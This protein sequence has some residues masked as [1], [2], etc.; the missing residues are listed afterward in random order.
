MPEGGMP[1][2]SIPE[3]AKSPPQEISDAC[4]LPGGACA[5]PHSSVG[6]E[7]GPSSQSDEGVPARKPPRRNSLFNALL[8]EGTCFE[9][10]HPSELE[11][12]RTLTQGAGRMESGQPDQSEL[13]E[14]P[15][16][17]APVAQLAA[18]DAPGPS[19]EAQTKKNDPWWG[20]ITV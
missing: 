5:S 17:C 11:D 13:P 20:L 8:S 4:K 14:P 18:K 10:V 19:D 15:G 7:V 16:A 2:G 9:D 12:R 6:N 1:G 3:G